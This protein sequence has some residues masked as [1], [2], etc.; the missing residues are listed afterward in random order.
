MYHVVSWSQIVG[1]AIAKVLGLGVVKLGLAFGSEV[2]L[3]LVLAAIDLELVPGLEAEIAIARRFGIVVFAL[4]LLVLDLDSWLG[5]ATGSVVGGFGLL[6]VRLQC[7]VEVVR[8]EVHVLVRRIQG[9][10][11]M[12]V[13]SL[14]WFVV[15]HSR[16]GCPGCVNHGYAW[17]RLLP[18]QIK[19]SPLWKPFRNRCRIR[20]EDE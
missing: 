12:A 14:L 10:M 13:R 20:I 9:Y 1:V 4:A 6:E 3:A 5:F 8:R 17:T 15:E 11:G 7:K 16:S 18:T 19:A 2:A